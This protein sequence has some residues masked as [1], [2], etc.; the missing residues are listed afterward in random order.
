M[1]YTKKIL[2]TAREYNYYDGVVE[3][4]GSTGNCG[5]STIAS[6]LLIKNKEHFEYII[7]NSAA[8]R[9]LFDVHEEVGDRIK[10]WVKELNLKILFSKKYE[11][12]YSYSKY[13]LCMILVEINKYED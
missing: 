1:P 7:K 3:Y 6:G 5:V 13:K 8:N 9:L 10:K 12:R 11:S 4:P 2:Q